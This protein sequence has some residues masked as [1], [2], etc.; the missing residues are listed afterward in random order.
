MIWSGLPCPVDVTQAPL[1]F[2]AGF[3][4]E[5]VTI[6]QKDA[7]YKLPPGMIFRCASPGKLI[8]SFPQPLTER[9]FGNVFVID[10]DDCKFLWEIVV[11]KEI[12]E[13]GNQFAPGQ[14]PAGT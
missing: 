3:L 9:L 11:K 13:R 6:N 12:V 4:S 1:E 7:G 8:D 10:S 5:E 14:V 2:G